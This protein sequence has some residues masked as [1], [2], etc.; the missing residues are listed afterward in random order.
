MDNISENE[1]RMG[2]IEVPIDRSYP[3][4]QPLKF[5]KK[6]INFT[7]RGWPSK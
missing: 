2:L 4:A 5:S 1:R 6:T 7:G 3:D